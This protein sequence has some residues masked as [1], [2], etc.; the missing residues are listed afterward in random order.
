MTTIGEHMTASPHTVGRDAS[1]SSA[2][3]MMREHGCRHL[4]VLHGGQLVGVVSDRDVYLVEALDDVDENRVTVEEAM[5]QEVYSV[6]PDAPLKEVV[7]EMAAK[8]YGAAI[9]MEGRKVVGI[10]TTIDAL[11][12]LG[13]RL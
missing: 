13:E 1:L 5:S 4:P 10:F 8:K 12:V 2:S 6:A 3:A 7:R 11:V 9:V